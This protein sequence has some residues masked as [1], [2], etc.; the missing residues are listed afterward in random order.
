VLRQSTDLI[1]DL[2]RL[3]DHMRE[4]IAEEIEALRT[5]L[6]V[7]YGHSRARRYLSDQ[8]LEAPAIE[9]LLND[10]ERLL[11]NDLLDARTE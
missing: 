4:D 11:L 3:I 9:T 5:E 8:A 1:G 10:A 7:L 6:S 2:L